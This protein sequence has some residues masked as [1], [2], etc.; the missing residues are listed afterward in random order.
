MTTAALVVELVLAGMLMLAA[1]LLPAH[2]C[3]AF[4]GALTESEIAI[5][6]AAGFILGVITDRCADSILELWDGRQRFKVAWHPRLWEQREALLQKTI[7]QDPFPEDWMHFRVLTADEAAARWLEQLRVRVRIARMVVLLAPALTVS[8]VW[9][10]WPEPDIGLAVVLPGF[11]LSALLVTALLARAE[12]FKPPRTSTRKEE[13]TRAEYRT[14]LWRSPAACWF[15]LELSCGIVAVVLA[16][17][18]CGAWHWAAGTLALGAVF[19]ALATVA[20]ERI[21]RTYRHYLW[22]VCRFKDEAGLRQACLEQQR[23][24]GA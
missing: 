12:P 9:S 10:L 5:A 23:A 19:T 16:A 11:H 6:I 8:A 7:A 3:G 15:G 17:K 24:D 22:D 13:P 4:K 2:A 14:W 18:T 20:W 1:L 21:S